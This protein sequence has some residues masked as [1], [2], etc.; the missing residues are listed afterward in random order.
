M[1]TVAP[2][3]PLVIVSHQTRLWMPRSGPSRRMVVN[4]W[5]GLGAAGSSPNPL[6]D[7]LLTN[8]QFFYEWLLASVRELNS[9]PNQDKLPNKKVGQL[10]CTFDCVQQFLNLSSKMPT[11]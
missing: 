6:E 2:S 10:R 4:C 3:D 7:N 8:I 5:A 1:A 9:L 11:V